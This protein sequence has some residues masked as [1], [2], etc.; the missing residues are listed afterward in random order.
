[1]GFFRY[2]YAPSERTR[3]NSVS[4][5]GTLTLTVKKINMGG[6]EKHG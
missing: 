2:A 6:A 4:E 3:H 1:M 5:G